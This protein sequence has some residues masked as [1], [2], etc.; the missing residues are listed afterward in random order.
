[1][2]MAAPPREVEEET[3]WMLMELNNTVM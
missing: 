3:P 1:M 2:G